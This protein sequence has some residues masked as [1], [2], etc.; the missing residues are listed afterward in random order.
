MAALH[1]GIGPLWHVPV[2]RYHTLIDRGIL[3]PG[4]RVELLEGIIVQKVSKNPPHRIATRLSRLA[5]ERVIPPNW[6]VDAQEPITLQASEPEPDIAVIRGDTR[7]YARRHPGLGDIGL[8]VEVADT[9]MDRDRIVKKRIY[10]AAGI[11]FYWLLDLNS[12]K[13]ETYSEPKG[14]EYA[15]ATEHAAHESVTVILD[16]VTVG[17]VAVSDLLP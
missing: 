12:R 17:S 3:G 7:M 9:T 11:P 4:D 8:V 15:S 16:G 2:E 13:L 10:A 14:S 5:L 6:Y 1:S